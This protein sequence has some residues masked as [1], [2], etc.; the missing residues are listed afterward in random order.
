MAARLVPRST[1][2][3]RFGTALLLAFAL[4]TSAHAV[5]DDTPD[6][7]DGVHK[8]MRFLRCA[9]EVMLANDPVSAGAATTDCVAL[10]LSE[11]H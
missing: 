6:T 3:V 10:Y 5:T 1:R 2:S 7:S 9:V 11:A 8:L 4:A